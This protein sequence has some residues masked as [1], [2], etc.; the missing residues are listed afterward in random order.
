MA[1]LGS[2]MAVGMDPDE[3]CPLQCFNQ[4]KCDFHDYTNAFYCDC[5]LTQGGGFQGIHCETPFLE[6]TDGGRRAWRCMNGGMCKSGD[7][8]E[9]CHCPDEFVGTRCEIFTGPVDGV[10]EIYD[11]AA[12][13]RQFSRGAISI[14]TMASLVLAFACFSSGFL[15]GRR[16]RSSPSVEFDSNCNSQSQIENTEPEFVDSQQ[17]DEPP[18]LSK[19]L[20]IT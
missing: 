9:V 1:G 17:D 14:V 6:C 19:D 3:N 20:Q 8:A 7:T 2:T 18:E 5:P 13:S 10:P 15:V 11:V 12:D 16:E 4:G